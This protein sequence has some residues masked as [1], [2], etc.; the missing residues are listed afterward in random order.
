MSK[1]YKKFNSFSDLKV[2]NEIE[3][4]TFLLQLKEILEEENKKNILKKDK[5]KIFNTIFSDLFK[6]TDKKNIKFS[7]SPNVIKEIQTLN[8]DQVINYLIH[9]YRYEIFP[10]LKIKDNHYHWFPYLLSSHSVL[11]SGQ[12]LLYLSH[13]FI[14]YMMEKIMRL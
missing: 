9:R 13:L 11:S 2:K 8:R 12:T 5:K 7:L 10:Q 1:I 6:T 14:Q 3:K 4:N